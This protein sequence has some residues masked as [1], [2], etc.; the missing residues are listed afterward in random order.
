[1]NPNQFTEVRRTNIFS[2][3]MSSVVGIFL[4]VLMFIGALFLLFYN[5]G[6]VNPADVAATAL[7][8]PANS[9]PA[10]QYQ[11]V[12]HLVSVTAEVATAELVG[13]GLALVPGQYLAVTRNVEMFAWD[14]VANARSQTEL[15]GTEVTETTYTYNT[16][17]TSA[18]KDS[19]TFRQTAGHT[20]PPQTLLGQSYSVNLATIGDYTFLPREAVLPGGQA[21]TLTPETTQLTGLQ[22][23]A[24][25]GYIYQ[26]YLE[27]SSSTMTNPQ[28]GDIRFS[29]NV[30]RPGFVGTLFGKLATAEQIIAYDLDGVRLYNL[31]IGDRETG[32]AQMNTQFTIVIWLFRLAGFLLLWFGL[33]S[34]LSPLTTL[35]SVIPI[36]GRLTKGLVAGATFVAALVLSTLTIIVAILF[37]NFLVLLVVIFL[38]A[39][40]LYFGFKKWRSGK[41]TVMAEV[42]ANMFPASLPSDGAFMVSSLA[43]SRVASMVPPN[44]VNPPPQPLLDYIV[45]T[46]SQGLGREQIKQNLISSGWAPEAVETALQYLR[47]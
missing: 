28:V 32:I 2:R 1:M 5:E 35:A 7:V 39:G 17:W 46:S 16:K 44:P 11:Y 9:A 47:K 12:G 24:E 45:S 15:G 21:L 41:P 22:Q 40:G 42:K 31:N 29:Y 13:D 10:S 30:L 8:I 23:L 43:E 33:M 25:G 34:I 18:P 26:P 6:R 27:N 36:L 3:L 37:H 20:N 4:G 38:A 19:S 14:E